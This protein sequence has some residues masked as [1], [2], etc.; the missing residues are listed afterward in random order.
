MMSLARDHLL[1]GLGPFCFTFSL[2]QRPALLF[3][4]GWPTNSQMPA[5]QQTLSFAQKKKNRFSLV[6]LTAWDHVAVLAIFSLFSSQHTHR[7]PS[8]LL[9]REVAE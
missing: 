2:R 6:S 9:W 3:S 1:P 7:I 4:L 5:H 8:L